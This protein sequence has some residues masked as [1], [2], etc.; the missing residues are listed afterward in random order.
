M[1]ASRLFGLRGLSIQLFADLIKRFA[2]PNEK[3]GLPAQIRMCQPRLG[4]KGVLELF[5]RTAPLYAEY[6]V[7]IHGTTDRFKVV[8]G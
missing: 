4:P 2:E 3:N 6:A 8:A 1:T 7:G 5:A